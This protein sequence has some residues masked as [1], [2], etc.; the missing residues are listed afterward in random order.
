MLCPVN[1]VESIENSKQHEIPPLVG[2]FTFFPCSIIRN[3]YYDHRS[4]SNSQSWQSVISLEFLFFDAIEKAISFSPRNIPIQDPWNYHVTKYKLDVTAINNQ[5]E[6]WNIQLQSL[7][8]WP[9]VSYLYRGQNF[10]PN[11]CLKSH[12]SRLRLTIIF[13]NKIFVWE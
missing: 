12:Y 1:T 9:K 11:N 6:Q 10:G 2:S 8:R 5:L 7:L 4:V 13:S 3:W